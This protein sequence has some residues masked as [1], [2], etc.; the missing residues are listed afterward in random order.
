MS[1]MTL[2]SRPHPTQNLVVYVYGANS[3]SLECWDHQNNHACITK[4]SLTILNITQ[5]IWPRRQASDQIVQATHLSTPHTKLKLISFARKVRIGNWEQFQGNFGHSFKES[6]ALY[7][8]FKGYQTAF[9][10]CRMARGVPLL[11]KKDQN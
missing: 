10:V 11:P 7:S 6:Q 8:C 5:V 4:L 3:S 2:S 1:K 9:W